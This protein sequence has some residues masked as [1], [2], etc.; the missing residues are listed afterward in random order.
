MKNFTFTKKTQQV[1][2]DAKA[3]AKA[4]QHSNIHPEH[5]LYCLLQDQDGICNAAIYHLGLNPISIA[6]GINLYLKGNAI[7]RVLDSA[8]PYFVNHTNKMLQVAKDIAT[9]SGE[10]D[11]AQDHLILAL[12]Q[13]EGSG[14]NVTRLFLREAGITK[15]K[16]I[17]ALEA[18]AKNDLP[19]NV[20]KIVEEKKSETK[21]LDA[22]SRDLTAMAKNGKLSPVIGRHQETERLLQILARKTKNNALLLGEAGVGKSSLVEGLAQRLASGDVPAPLQG[23][24]LLS[25]DMPAIIAG[26]KQ[27]GEFE[28]RM[29]KILNEMMENNNIILF[30]DEI[31]SVLGGGNATANAADMLK[32]ALARGEFRCVGNTTLSDYKTYIEKDKSMVRRF[33]KVAVNPMTQQ[34]AIAVLR[35]L[36]TQYEKYHNVNISDEALVS[37]VT[38]SERYVTDRN[39]PD[40]A[41]D[42]LDEAAAQ[43]AIQLSLPPEEIQS[44]R[45]AIEMLTVEVTSLESDKSNTSKRLLTDLAKDLNDKK[46][47]LNELETKWNHEVSTL[48]QLKHKKAQLAEKEELMGNLLKNGDLGVA[49]ELK[50]SVIPALL[51]E[52]EKLQDLINDGNFHNNSEAYVTGND[53]AALIEKST[54]IPAGDMMQSDK[55]KLLHMEENIGE[56]VI[57][58]DPALESIANAIRLA[59]AGLQDGTK[60]QGSFML[61]GTSGSGK[62]YIAKRLAFFMFGSEEAMIRLDMSEYMEKHAASRLIGA[63]P[64]YVG[65]DEGGLLTEAVKRRPYSVVLFDE[66]EKA[67]PDVFNMLLQVLDDGRLTD[68]KGTTVDFTNTIIILTTNLGARHIIELGFDGKGEADELVLKA[69]HKHFRPEFINRVSDIIVTNMLSKE[70]LV[71]IADNAMKK[72]R[73]QLALKGITLEITDAAKQLIVDDGYQPEMGAR[74]LDRSIIRLLTQPASKEVLS[75]R[76][77]HGETLCVDIHEDGRKLVF[78]VKESNDESSNVH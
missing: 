2:D 14:L 64:G 40:K 8:D 48:N 6:S 41:I 71:R 15:D 69:I 26:T 74:P 54:G 38:L 25:L 35:G 24:R 42:L 7:P 50:Y 29:K 11:I 1:I 53:I 62:T 34:E 37:A 32:P 39:L 28:E 76:V 47:K 70:Q 4:E 22:F 30:I 67:H 13:T 51:K 27:R 73:K 45:K 68:S 46:S 20:N 5:L 63:P 57:G 3:L 21:T 17:A 56:Y 58:Q 65:Y 23:M 61:A 10:K 52:V 72:I 36:K 33:S 43:L 55:D 66:I 59:R 9:K 18:S 75:N 49:S 77:K 78:T 19:A 31:H 12:F 60:P 44:L 16:L